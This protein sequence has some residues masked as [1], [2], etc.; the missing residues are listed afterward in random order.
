MNR[1]IRIISLLAGA[2]LLSLGACSNGGKKANPVEEEEEIVPEWEYSDINL[3][4]RVKFKKGNWAYEGDSGST[5][6]VDYQNNLLTTD[7]YVA[8]KT[9][10]SFS[11]KV[12]IRDG[13]FHLVFGI[14]NCGAP[15][16]FYGYSFNHDLDGRLRLSS[17]GKGYLG[18]DVNT[19]YYDVPS[20]SADEFYELKLVVLENGAIEGYINDVLAVKSYDA[21]YAGGYIGF[22]NFHANVEFKDVKVGLRS[23]DEHHNFEIL[24]ESPYEINEY[25]S[26]YTWGNWTIDSQKLVAQNSSIGDHFSMSVLHQK[27]NQNL[28]FEADVIMNGTSAA[29]TFGVGKIYDPS[30]GWYAFA[31]DKG[32]TKS[33]RAFAVNKG[34]IGTANTALK[35]LTALQ[36]GSVA[37][38]VRII[39]RANG[40]LSFYGDGELVGHLY[41][42]TYDGGFLGFNTFFSS[43]TFSNVSIKLTDDNVDI[44]EIKLSGIN[45]FKFEKGLN[46]YREDLDP[47][48]KQ[49]SVGVKANKNI[50]TYINDSKKANSKEAISAGE[51]LLEIMSVNKKN[52]K[53]GYVDILLSSFY[54]ETYRPAIHYTAINNWMNDPNG[55]MYDD[56]TGLYHLFYQKRAGLAFDGTLTWGHSVSKDMIHWK[57]KDDAIFYKNGYG[58]CFSGS[59]VVDRDNTSGLFNDSIPAGSRLINIVTYHSEN[60]TIGLCYSLDQGETW[61]EYPTPLIAN[62]NKMYGADFRDPKVIRYQDDELCPEGIWLMVTGGWA[63]VRIF[64][65]TNLIDWEYQSEFKTRNGSVVNS[66]CPDFFPLEVNGD[67]TNKKW[68]LS[69]AGTSYIVG[70]LSKVDGKLV[71]V[72]ESDAKAMFHDTQLWANRGEAYATQSFYNTKDGRRVIMSWMIENLADQFEDKTWNG[73]QTIPHEV[74]LKYKNGEYSLILNPIREIEDIRENKD[75]Y[76]LKGKTIEKDGDLVLDRGGRNIYDFNMEVNVSAANSLEVIFSDT[77]SLFYDVASQTY[78]ITVFNKVGID[79]YS[80]NSISLPMVDGKINIRAI[81]DVSIFEIFLNNGEALSMGLFYTDDEY[82]MIQI[83]SEGGPSTIE[84]L[85]VY[86]LE[87]A[88]PTK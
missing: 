25:R 75:S 5:T 37:I 53:S 30:A 68:V 27:P 18:Y 60:P 7:I 21:V 29:L 72:A 69:T 76:S 58:L 62:T 77:V 59:G 63:P 86:N 47:E 43:A 51:N 57:D 88:L 52:K 6:N 83:R 32:G 15:T 3:S 4:E 73:S 28:I 50:E 9:D 82:Q 2:A 84:S 40:V 34:T 45:G 66:E 65:S 71:F 79:P 23:W 16:S 20:F 81:I 67:E 85:D 87:R 35:P 41:D 14:D 55:L 12:K 31:I 39:A 42:S 33:F 70:H 1:K 38:N 46:V 17:E 54:G 26:G 61:I 56:V 44:N 13:T 64:T 8:S 10:L 11:A 74:S 36:M 49:V 22:C 80:I 24:D 78:S 19:H 48:I